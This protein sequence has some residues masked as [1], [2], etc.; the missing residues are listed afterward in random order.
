MTFYQRKR[1]KAKSERGKRMANAR[2]SA[3]RARRDFLAAH[4]PCVT[5]RVMR[6][7]ID[8][9]EQTGTM[10]EI[11]MRDFDSVREILRKLRGIGLTLATTKTF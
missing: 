10:I 7:I 2:W 11:V 1:A 5:G 8:I 4:E 3:D 6:R 9:D